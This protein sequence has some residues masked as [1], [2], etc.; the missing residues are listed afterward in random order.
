MAFLG[1]LVASSAFADFK[2]MKI[3]AENDPD[4]LNEKSALE[5]LNDA[6][7]L[8]TPAPLLAASYA[9]STPAPLLDATFGSSTASSAALIGS[10]T[11]APPMLWSDTTA[12]ALQ[13]G[14][15]LLKLAA[16][17]PVALIRTPAFA[18]AYG[19]SYSALAPSYA[20]GVITKS[21]AYIADAAAAQVSV[22]SAPAPH[23]QITINKEV[24]VPYYVQVEKKIPYPVLVR[25]P[26]PYPVTV[27]KHVPYAVRVNV[28]RP[29]H[30]PQPY[31]VEVEKRVPYPVDKPIPY[32][33]KV[34][35][36]RPYPVHVPVEKPVPYAVEKP[37]PYPVRV[38]VDRPYPVAKP[39][40]YPITVEKPVPYPVER[41][42]PFPVEKPVPYAVEKKVP[43]PVRYDVPVKVPI[44]YEVKVPVNIDRP[45][46]IPVEKKVPYP[47]SVPYE[48]KVPVPVQGPTQRFATVHYYQQSPAIAGAA[49]DSATA[50]A[51]QSMGYRGYASG[52]API[53]IWGTSTPAA[54]ISG[55]DQSMNSFSSSTASPIGLYSTTI[56]TNSL[57][58]SID[59]KLSREGFIQK[60]SDL[61]G[62]GLQDASLI[63]S[64]TLAP[65]GTKLSG[66]SSQFDASSSSSSMFNSM[67][68][69]E[70]STERAI[71]MGGSSTLA[72]DC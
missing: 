45:I 34:P 32:E 4:C 28:D 69:S 64:T 11:M 48:V 24:P 51:G 44:P 35:V 8:S 65:F 22:A 67:G 68:H 18:T 50:L 2:R 37:M 23:H 71:S 10:S 55:A 20:H 61:I 1:L 16:P 13:S 43:Y 14:Q 9:S 62:M 15:A 41:R 17:E 36:D 3:I 29:V 60:S 33:V 21:D 56:G 49:Y 19:R 5:T 59:S 39:V 72:D 30:V 38:N 52:A 54:L 6:A 40:P 42:I 25:V 31:P 66:L 7:L 12:A 26:H 70:F 63:G 57:L 47:V 53:A 58:G 27:E 46:P